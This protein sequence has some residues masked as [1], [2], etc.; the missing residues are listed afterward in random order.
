MVSIG[1]GLMGIIACKIC[2]SISKTFANIYR[3]RP[4]GTLDKNRC[5]FVKI[6]VPLQ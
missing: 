1:A 3:T 5:H 2:P 6:P 4:Y